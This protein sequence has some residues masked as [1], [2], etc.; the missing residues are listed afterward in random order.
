MIQ[1]YILYGDEFKIIRQLSAWIKERQ[2]IDTGKKDILLKDYFT[3]EIFA[4]AINAIVFD[5]KPVVS[6]DRMHAIDIETQ[7]VEED[8]GKERLDMC[9]AFE[10][11]KE[12]GREEG[13]K[14]GLKKGKEDKYKS[15]VTA[16]GNLEKRGMND[17]EIAS[18]LGISESELAEAFEY[19]DKRKL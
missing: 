3:P 2:V 6:P 10:G 13:L 16:A 8:E 19:I 11:I 5:G 9:E 7:H 14:E 12:E 1:F 4:D 18:I 15:W 17:A